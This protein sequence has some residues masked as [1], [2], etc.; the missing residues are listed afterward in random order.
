[1]RP[2]ACLTP[3]EETTESYGCVPVKISRK[4]Q[5][6]RLRG[7]TTIQGLV[8]LKSQEK[9]ECL[10]QEVGDSVKCCTEFKTVED[11]KVFI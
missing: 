4:A 8:G 11:W 1:M 9:I 5:P 2:P 3:D 10:K 6:V 7:K